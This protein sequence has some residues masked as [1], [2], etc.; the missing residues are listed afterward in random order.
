[1]PY[2]THAEM[3]ERFGATEVLDLLDRDRDGTADSG[4]YDAIAADADA[5]ING[6][7]RAANHTLPLTS[8]DP[9]LRDIAAAVV[10]FKLWDK[11][12]PE[13]V[14][15]RYE[16]AI[17]RLGDIARGLIVLDVDTPATPTGAV[18]YT[19]RTRTFSDTTLTSFMGGYTN[20]DY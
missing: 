9:V 12:A 17:K 16:D 18:A 20:D 4:I 2:V 7:L 5:L 15:K 6:Y 13:E 8:V 10:R 11:R 14:R 3:V 19:E 1:M